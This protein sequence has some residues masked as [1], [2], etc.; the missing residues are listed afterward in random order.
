MSAVLQFLHKVLVTGALSKGWGGPICRAAGPS[1]QTH[2]IESVVW[3]LFAAVTFSVYKAGPKFNALCKSIQ[4][5][6]LKST[7]SSAARAFELFMAF[8]HFGMFAQI[9]YYKV[10]ILSLVNMIQPC[11][12]ILLLQGIA[13]YSTG[14]TGVVISLCIL[15]SLTGTLL[16]MLFPDT[17]GLD[18]P[19]EM[20]AYWIQHYLV[21][22]VP[23]Y[24]LVRRDYVALRHASFLNVFLG[25]WVLLVAHF[26]LFEVSKTTVR[27]VIVLHM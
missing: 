18:Q 6:L 25:L 15:P 8:V 22:A 19:L 21:Q 7:P 26:S 20:E 14:T 4:L 23:L 12:V 11:H 2:L 27:V 17:G 3:L 5:D 10:N 24:L 16:A 9:I 1:M 13:L